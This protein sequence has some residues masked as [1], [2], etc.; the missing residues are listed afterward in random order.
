MDVNSCCILNAGPGAWAFEEHARRLARALW[1]DVSDRPRTFN[2]VLGLADEDVA[3]VARSAGVFIP[4]PS[5]ELAA[6]KRLLATAF[7]AAGVA[8]PRT[9]LAETPDDTYAVARADPAAEWCLKWPTGCGAAGHRLIAGRESIPD[10]WP[11]PSVVQEFVR[12][13]RP[14]VYRLYAAGGQTFGWNVR[15]F[16]AGVRP[17]PWVAHARGTRYAAPGDAPPEAVRQAT[18]ALSAVGLLDSF[19]CCDLLHAPD[20][21]WLVLEVGT[22]G[23]HNHVDRDL[24]LPELEREIDHRLAGAFW[25]RAGR[26]P[27]WEPGAWRPRGVDGPS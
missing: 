21:R 10:D 1:L 7:A 14:E 8:T 20:G 15:R 19:G 5:I 6:D 24:C 3:A 17:S 27:P 2:Y 23:V 9:N 16:P 12:L 4:F 25:A 18:S 11:R 13:D 26:P 22:D